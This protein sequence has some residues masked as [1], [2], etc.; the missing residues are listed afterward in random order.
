MCRRVLA[1]QP[2]DDLYTTHRNKDDDES[3]TFV[4]GRQ[5]LT[6][7]HSPPLWHLCRQQNNIPQLWGVNVCSSAG[8]DLYL[9]CD[10]VVVT[11]VGRI[12]GAFTV[13][14]TPPGNPYALNN[15][16]LRGALTLLLHMNYVHQNLLV[17][18]VKIKRNL[19][20]Q[21][22]IKLIWHLRDT[23]SP[24]STRMLE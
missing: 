18:I 6:T 1:L 15:N 2:Q 10:F 20:A 12:K 22:D 23:S 17:I 8:L 24:S 9:C 14:P 4:F 19:C 3:L 5:P 7:H 11:R 16:I 13:W 21:F